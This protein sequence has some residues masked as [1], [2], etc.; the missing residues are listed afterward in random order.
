MKKGYLSYIKGIYLQVEVNKNK[1]L[2][3]TWPH[4]DLWNGISNLSGY[5]KIVIEVTFSNT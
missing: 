3:A 4:I 5:L 2:A 1:L